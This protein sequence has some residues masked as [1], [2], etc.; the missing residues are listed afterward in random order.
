MKMWDI[1]AISLLAEGMYVW[2]AKTKPSPGS[3]QT[4]EGEH[5][6]W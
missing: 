4:L 2:Y 3:L 6:H 1:A 5:C